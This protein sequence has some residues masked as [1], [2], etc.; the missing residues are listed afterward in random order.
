MPSAEVNPGLVALA[1]R[2]SLFTYLK[3]KKMVAERYLVRH[4]SSTQRA[5][6][7]GELENAYWLPGAENPADGLSRARSYVVPLQG[8]GRLPKC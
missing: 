8:A 4:L 7:G 1:G 3:T 6:A 5:L 2:E